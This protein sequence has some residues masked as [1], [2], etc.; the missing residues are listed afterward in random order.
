M[1]EK[2]V[3][4]TAIVQKGERMIADRIVVE[5]GMNEHVEITVRTLNTAEQAL[6]EKVEWLQQELKSRPPISEAPDRGW[7]ED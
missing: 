1:S 4:Y 6:A 2:K 5:N 7:P 3:V